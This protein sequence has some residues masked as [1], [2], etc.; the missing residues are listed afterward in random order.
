ML[1]PVAEASLCNLFIKVVTFAFFLSKSRI[2]SRSHLIL[3]FLV[4]VAGFRFY[5]KIFSIEHRSLLRDECSIVSRPL[6]NFL[7]LLYCFRD[8]FKLDTKHLEQHH[9][10][11]DH[12]FE[13]RFCSAA[14]DENKA[15]SNPRGEGVY[16]R[17][18]P[19]VSS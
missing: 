3:S 4:T 13:F 17:T 7:C 8:H 16:T 19:L 2:A 10:R 6:R 12:D 18:R 5:L 14:D 11:R 15:R 1:G 9:K